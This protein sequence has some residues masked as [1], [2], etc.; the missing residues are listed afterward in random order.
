MSELE[1]LITEFAKS[2]YG[3]IHVNKDEKFRYKIKTLMLRTM[4]EAKYDPAKFAEKVEQL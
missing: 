1:Q 3:E 4:R 2:C